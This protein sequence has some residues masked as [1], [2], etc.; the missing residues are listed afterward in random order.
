LVSRLF[1]SLRKGLD[2]ERVWRRQSMQRRVRPVRTFSEKQHVAPKEGAQNRGMEMMNWRSLVAAAFG[3]AL[4]L[5]VASVA[6]AESGAGPE[7]MSMGNMCMVMFGY[8]MIHIH[9][10]FIRY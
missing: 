10:L 8:D 6:R 3:A 5:S 7:A 9:R 2:G 1:V 4:S